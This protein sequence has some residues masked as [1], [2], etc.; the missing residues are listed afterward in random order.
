MRIA[1][2][3]FSGAGKSTLAKKLAQELNIEPLCFDRVHF[4]WNAA[5]TY[6]QIIVVIRSGRALRQYLNERNKK[7]D[8]K[9][10][11]DNGEV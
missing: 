10:N 8:K 6:P 1:I 3:G 7:S 9:E 2:I 11:E 4:H 5:R